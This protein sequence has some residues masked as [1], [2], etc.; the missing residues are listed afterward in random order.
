MFHYG[1]QLDRVWSVQF[2]WHCVPTL[3]TGAFALPPWCKRHEETPAFPWIRSVQMSGEHSRDTTAV[4]GC[5]KGIV[6]R[7]Q[8]TSH[9]LC[10]D[11][12]TSA[13]LS[14][15]PS[16][17]TPHEALVN[18][19]GKYSCRRGRL[20]MKVFYANLKGEAQSGQTSFQSTDQWER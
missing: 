16:I 15:A 3:H 8:M 5:D 6:G 4:T 11:S 9:L 18:K 20:E 12:N 19:F 17:L 10:G 2:A 13:A 14:Q 1:Q 7:T